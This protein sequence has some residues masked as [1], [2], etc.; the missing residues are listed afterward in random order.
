MCRTRHLRF[1]DRLSSQTGEKWQEEGEKAR[2][3]PP[4]LPP[5]I[6]K[7]RIAQVGQEKQG[8]HRFR[9]RGKGTNVYKTWIIVD[10][11]PCPKLLNVNRKVN[12]KKL[13]MRLKFNRKI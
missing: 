2:Q 5:K 13:E 11:S 7:Q 6:Q 4:A 12:R 3:I 9:S 10:G 1:P 8:R